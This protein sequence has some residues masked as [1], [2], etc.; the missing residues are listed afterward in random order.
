MKI[1]GLTRPD[2]AVHAELAGASYLGVILASGPRLLDAE[3]AAAVLGPRRHG[4]CRVAVFGD[5]APD[6][7]ARLAEQLDLDVA[8]LHGNASVRDVER[9]Q[10]STRRAVWPVLRVQGTTLPPNAAALAEA[11]GV[12]VLDANVVGQLGG[13]GVS[14][15]WSGLRDSIEQLRRDVPTF[16]L[17]VAGGLRPENV[18]MAIRLL[19]PQVVDV[20]SGVEVS[21]GV[22]DPVA[23]ERFVKAVKD[24][25]G[26][27]A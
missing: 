11:A 27:A 25:M 15:D 4:I 2:D 17:V 20:S 24:A 19:A 13:T 6:H 10:R 5:G 9:I 16:R 7:I 14:L 12:L 8:Q 22:K 21:P 23:V 26:N 3:H 18:A 1:C